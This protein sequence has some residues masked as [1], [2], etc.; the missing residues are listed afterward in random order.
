MAMAVPVHDAPRSAACCVDRRDYRVAMVGLSCGYR[1][2]IV[3]LSCC[4]RVACCGERFMGAVDVAQVTT[5]HVI[6][7]VTGSRRYSYTDIQPIGK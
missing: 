7:H 2:A 5:C 6:G 1:V 4:S 3:L